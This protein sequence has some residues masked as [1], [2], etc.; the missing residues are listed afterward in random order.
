MAEEKRYYY[1]AKSGKG[2]LNLKSP[3]S[4]KEL[5]DYDEI[6]KE[7]F[8]A[9]TYHE[10]HVETAKEKAAREKKQEIARLKKQLAD[11]DYC[12][13][14]IAEGVATAEEYADVLTQRAEWRARINELEGELE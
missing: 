1:K 10:P 2:Y 13:S 9:E 8:D 6:T 12:V 14:K 3:L 4:K 5:K 7:V 11:T